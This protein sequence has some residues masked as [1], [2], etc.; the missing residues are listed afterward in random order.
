MVA[1][2]PGLDQFGRVGNSSGGSSDLDRRQLSPILIDR[3]NHCLR[4][5]DVSS[6]LDLVSLSND[7]VTAP[8]GLLTTCRIWSSLHRLIG[9]RSRFTGFSVHFPTMSS[10]LR[11]LV[12]YS[13]LSRPP[14]KPSRTQS[15]QTL[16]TRKFPST[17]LA[18]CWPAVSSV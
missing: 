15:T 1:E 5:Q 10:R 4:L 17:S 12:V 3:W 6:N 9:P 13:G 18:L 8:S 14:V 11:G 2:D 16:G 7:T